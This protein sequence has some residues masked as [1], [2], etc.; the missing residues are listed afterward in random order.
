[1]PITPSVM[2]SE[3]ERSHVWTTVHR[4]KS[5]VRTLNR[6]LRY[7]GFRFGLLTVGAVA[8]G[9]FGILFLLSL[10]LQAVRGLTA[11]NTWLLLLPFASGAFITAPIA[12]S[13]TA[14]MARL[15][16][17]GAVRQGDHRCS[18]RPPSS[19]PRAPSWTTRKHK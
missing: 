14:S 16:P 12:G 7:V 3:D 6:L 2:L 10:Y 11:L 5:T 15:S 1:M 19:M 4:D 9:A 18:P 8:L 13:R 17:A